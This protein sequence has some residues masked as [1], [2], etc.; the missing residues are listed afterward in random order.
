MWSLAPHD[1][2]VAL[3]LLDQVPVRVSAQGF[4]YLQPE[5]G[6]EDVVFTTLSFKDGRAAHIHTS[7]L[8]PHKR[9]QLTVVGSKRMLSFDDMAASEKVRIY[10]KGVDAMSA[11]PYESYAELLTLRQ[12]D[13]TIPHIPMREPLR[14]LCQDF[15]RAIDHGAPALANGEG[16]AAVLDVLA[17]AQR[18]LDSGGTPIDIPPP[19]R[20][21]RDP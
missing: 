10:D 18:S 21:E 14:A 12:G 7:W 5:S 3:Y 16:G 11:Q 6:I 4:C 13:V 2:S 15:L 17:A 19:T 8:D 1:I 9:R 20:T